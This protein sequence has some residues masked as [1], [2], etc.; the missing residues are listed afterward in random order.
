MAQ[1]PTTE[2]SNPK[3]QISNQAIALVVVLYSC[4]LGEAKGVTQHPSRML[5]S[6]QPTTEISNPK[7]QI[8]NQAIAFIATI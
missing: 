3:S 6:T 4:R 1:Q 5:G 7:S 2:I 8:S